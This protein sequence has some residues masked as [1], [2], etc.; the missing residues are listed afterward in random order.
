MLDA[1]GT[2][3]P[4]RTTIGLLGS[5]DATIAADT[6][7]WALPAWSRW[8]LLVLPI[9]AAGA[10]GLAAPHPRLYEALMSED[11]IVEW[12]QFVTI[13]LASGVFALVARAAWRGDRRGLAALFAL[14]AAAA[15]V[16][17]GEEI[18]WGQ[19]ILGLET[20]E[21]LDRIN[22]QGETN[23]HNIP[24]IQRMFN[25]GELLAGVY[26]FAIPILWWIPSIRARL[27]GRLDR[28]VVP[29]L[30]LAT[31]FFLP[32][33]YRAFRALFLPEAGERITQY[34]E[35][36]ELTLYLGTLIMGV[37]LLGVLRRRA[38]ANPS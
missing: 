21:V 30:A 28:L 33:A 25:I 12:L 22:H 16:V 27:A 18:S 38:S 23:I 4:R 31:L 26:G 6:H 10:V 7:E 3:T 32:F 1:E 36:P 24:L 37:A 2:V 29:P 11:R 9:V 17:A 8:P 15:F 5:I 35:L 13:L 34:G 19:R 20:P 14:V